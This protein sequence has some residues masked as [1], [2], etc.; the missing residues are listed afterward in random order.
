[1]PENNLPLTPNV[2]AL[3]P[4]DIANRTFPTVRKGLD[5][6]AVQHFLAEVAN[7]VRE[8]RN[9]LRVLS[10]APRPEPAPVP[11]MDE[12][13]LTK[14]LGDETTRV[15]RTA[16]ESAK[17]LVGTAESKAADLVAAA[18]ALALER[19]QE[20]ES[21]ARSTR[22]RLSEESAAQIEKTKT[23]CREMIEEAREARR[24]VLAD[25]V[26]RRRLLLVQ[27]EQ[28]RV[29]KETLVSAIDTVA[30]NVVT[31][32]DEVRAQLFGAEEGA[33]IMAEQAA[34]ELDQAL[35]SGGEEVDELVEE[36]LAK[37]PRPPDLS[38][39]KSSPDQAL[40]SNE[41]RVFDIE[42]D[43]P[44]RTLLMAPGMGVGSS[45]IKVTG[46]IGQAGTLANG[47]KGLREPDR[48]ETVGKP[49]VSEQVDSD[50]DTGANVADAAPPQ[51]AHP[52]SDEQSPVDQLFAKIRASRE[53]KTA[54]AR[55]VLTS[56]PHET[57]TGSL[58]KASTVVLDQVDGEE[59]STV[60]LTE[61]SDES[62]A[63]GE[64]LPEAISE[65]TPDE[66]LRSQ[67]DSLLEPAQAELSRALKKV[68]RE[69]QNLLL[70]ALRSRKKNETISSLVPGDAV[71]LRLVAAATPGVAA[72]IS[73]AN[74]FFEQA[75]RRSRRGATPASATEIADRLAVEILGSLT[76]RLTP[77]FAKESND[78]AV[79]AVG[80]VF[81]DWKATRVESL[82]VD[83]VTDAFGAGC[84]AV[85]S[86][87]KLA[88]KWNFD[89][90]GSSCPD[91]D[92][93]AVSGSVAAGSSFPTGHV[94]PPVHPGCRCFLS[95]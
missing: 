28:V 47:V 64:S 18:E 59:L 33:R 66:L 72:A 11:S 45:E 62:M 20:T 22:E 39:S 8:M 74:E 55:E 9:E 50:F 17:S 43:Q 76:S 63:A 16:R 15:L 93:N 10:V 56:L 84:V 46:P 87:K 95:L 1:M 86:T 29:G 14:A 49:D 36:V 73:A 21:F 77:S 12:E 69:E 82:A 51:S 31:S 80:S 52:V 3:N 81:R 89:D 67:R 78:E 38:A 42:R 32:F 5:A 61:Q 23:E 44:I 40:E 57:T 19:R 71:R 26:D 30:S 68:L 4:E 60:S 79:E 94:H 7:H 48:T 92:D 58:T 34:R 41:K 75:D 54:E 85:A 65:A 83:T 70:D 13:A 88:L 6:T 25:L 53:S 27:L 90:G 35:L 91:C 37:L 2:R 24:R